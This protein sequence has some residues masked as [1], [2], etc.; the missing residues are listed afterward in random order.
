M[1]PK[2]QVLKLQLH[3]SD[4][5][6]NHYQTH[7][8]TLVQHPSETDRRLMF[9]VAVYA[10]WAFEEPQF[11]KGLCV[12]E[13]PELWTL[14][15]QGQVSHWI[16][17]GQPEPKRLGQACGKSKAVTVYSYQANAAAWYETQ[18][19]KLRRYDKLAV[20]GIGEA[21]GGPL[22]KLLNEGTEFTAQIQDGSLWLS[23]GDA[24]VTLSVPCLKERG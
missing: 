5:E 8:L 18:A 21:E 6:N 4:F 1:A 19:D 24:Q 11:T 16:E 7:R 3:L 23:C 12:A 9:R 10:L 13:E 14:D 20:Y 17:L 2:G 15:L 22:E